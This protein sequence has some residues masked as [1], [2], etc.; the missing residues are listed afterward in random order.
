MES[1]ASMNP[2]VQWL[3]D[4]PRPLERPLLLAAFGGVGGDTAAA[5]VTYLATEWEAEPLATIDAEP[6]TNLIVTRPIVRPEDGERVIE[7]PQTTIA[8][9]RPEG[10]DRDIVLLVG[11]EPHLQWR[12]YA[13]AVGEI[14]DTLGVEDAVLVN[15]FTGATP[16]TRPT[17]VH[18]VGAHETLQALFAV[19]ARAPRYQG[20]ASYNMALGV[21]LREAGLRVGTLTAI[22]P[23]YIGVDPNP[24]A[25]RSLV[26]VI[27]GALGSATP[28]DEIEHRVAEVDEHAAGAMVRSDQLRTFVQNL[29]QQYDESDAGET[30]LS[31]PNPL[32]TLSVDELIGDVESFLRTRHPQA[33][34]SPD[35]EAHPR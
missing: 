28:T 10:A 24:Y 19:P 34:G 5:T 2:A 20:P 7:W 32:D 29:E 33:E 18:L 11:P 8:V 31:E 23:F 35:G 9:A 27:D 26:R 1:R 4:D 21:M 25:V 12:Q 30:V 16:H 15:S 6:F 14:L 22:A 3:T 17:P 13:A